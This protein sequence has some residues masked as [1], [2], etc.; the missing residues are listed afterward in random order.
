MLPITSLKNHLPSEWG[1]VYFSEEYKL[2]EIP[3]SSRLFRKL[4]AKV[5]GSFNLETEKI[6]RVKNPNLYLQYS[7]HKEMCLK[8]GGRVVELFHDTAQSN[9]TSIAATNLNY[10]F[11]S[12]S[13]FGYGVSFSP[14]PSYANKYSAKENGSKRAMIIADVLVRRCYRGSSEVVVPK[15]GYDTTTGNGTNVYVKYFDNEFY[16]KCVVYYKSRSIN[17]R[18][19]RSL[20]GW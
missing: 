7:L 2:E 14:S 5:Q 11:V 3:P 19:M 6:V 8:D 13:K 15:N 12:R 9:V 18:P 16:P 4:N 20:W 17:Y 1:I 10:R